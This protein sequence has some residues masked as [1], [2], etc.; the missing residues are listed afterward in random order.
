MKIS[1]HI[2]NILCFIFCL[3][4]IAQSSQT[5]GVRIKVFNIEN[6]RVSL[7]ESDNF[8][9]D[10]L[11]IR[12]DNFLSKKDFP[13]KK[14][15]YGGLHQR[16]QQYYKNIKIVDATITAHFKNGI[17]TSFNGLIVDS[18]K[19]DVNPKLS[20]EDVIEIAINSS[21]NH[22]MG[23][24]EITHKPELVIMSDFKNNENKYVLAYKLIVRNTISS[25][26]YIEATSGQIIHHQSLI[27]ASCT[28]R[29]NA[30]SDKNLVLNKNENL[31]LLIPYNAYAQTHYSYIEQIV[32]DYSSGKYNL[33]N[34]N[35]EAYYATG[36]R[37]SSQPLSIK[38]ISVNNL[39]ADTWQQ[40]DVNSQNVADPTIPTLKTSYGLDAFWAMQNTYDYFLNT[41]DRDSYDNFGSKVKGVVAMD[42]V[43]MEKTTYSL[44]AAWDIGSNTILYGDAVFSGVAIEP[45]TTIDITAHEFGH[46]FF[47]NS[48]GTIL[49]HPSNFETQS[50]SESFS[51]IWGACVENF[52]APYKNIWIIGDDLDPQYWVRSLEDPKS[53]QNPD[54]Y[55][56]QY[57]SSEF[58][59]N[60]AGVQNHWFYLLSEG[61]AGTN[62]LGYN[63]NITG[64]G[65]EDAAMIVYQ[66]LEYNYITNT[67]NYSDSR[68][69]SIQAAIDIF[70]TNTTEVELVMNAWCAVGVGEDC[71]ACDPYLNITMDVTSGN[72]DVRSAEISITATNTIEEDAYASYD[73][74]ETI[75]LNPGFHAESGSEF[76]AFILGC[77]DNGLR[78]ID[79]FNNNEYESFELMES[80]TTTSNLKVYPNPTENILIVN[81]IEKMMHIQIKDFSGFNKE[82]VKLARD[83]KNQVSLDLSSFLPGFYFLVVS[84]EN[85]MEEI[86]TIYKK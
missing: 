54:T 61:G 25:L 69:A 6:S 78:S 70:G 82:N 35:I 62:D 11:N 56:G 79:E 73:A 42:L 34:G 24:Y 39:V 57:W 3:E 13:A 48:I 16:Y 26:Y 31:D 85:G 50:L 75:F 7:S 2:I 15:K 83:E 14:D 41:H 84:F 72:G 23:D 27:E 37:T 46:G 53:L 76:N 8:I 30:K 36:D 38:I 28:Y 67:S 55:K 40:V 51:D 58:Y 86:K 66:M 10:Y 49:E 74:G 19:L 43:A 77:G 44:S 33:R 59:H 52:A 81:S 64:L 4:I 20:A 80:N 68:M 65:I 32:C 1:I 5:N 45:K 60:N 18:L 17:L 71:V 22:S 12:N 21:K 9:T 29:P 47:I 63:Y